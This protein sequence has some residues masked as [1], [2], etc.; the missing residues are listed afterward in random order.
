MRININQNIG[1]KAI[2]N[3]LRLTKEN[4]EKE[5]NLKDNQLNKEVLKMKRLKKYTIDGDEWILIN[6]PKCKGKQGIRRKG[7]LKV[8]CFVCKEYIGEFNF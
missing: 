2:E 5:V 6:Y 3:L 8:F 7:S 1:K 4:T